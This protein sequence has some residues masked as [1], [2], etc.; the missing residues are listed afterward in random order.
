MKS[1]K[2]IAKIFIVYVILAFFLPIVPIRERIYVNCGV[3]Y[4]PSC[5]IPHY[6][7]TFKNLFTLLGRGV[8]NK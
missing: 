7:I 3:V 4:N 1:L 2:I 6:S 8:I 5:D